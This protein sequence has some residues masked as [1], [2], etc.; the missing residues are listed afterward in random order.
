[1]KLLYFFTA[2]LN[3]RLELLAQQNSIHNVHSW[4]DQKRKKIAIFEIIVGNSICEQG[5]ELKR[6]YIYHINCRISRDF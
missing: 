6:K 5:I 4:K 2:L 1:M 3:V